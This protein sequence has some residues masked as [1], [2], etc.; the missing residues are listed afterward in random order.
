MCWMHFKLFSFQVMRRSFVLIA[1]AI[2][3]FGDSVT[4]SPSPQNRD[5][6]TEKSYGLSWSEFRQKNDG[7]YTEARWDAHVNRT[8][9]AVGSQ[10]KDLEE[11]WST[12]GKRHKRQSVC[13]DKEKK[14][15]RHTPTEKPPQE[16]STPKSRKQRSEKTPERMDARWHSERAKA[17]RERTLEQN[18]RDG[19]P[20]RQLRLRREVGGEE[21]ARERSRVSRRSGR[22]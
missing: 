18:V 13:A 8:D 7:A 11:Q 19:L 2:V 12:K 21:R 1:I 4:S 10:V 17:V 15:H 6:K 9:N 22:R 3:I 20:V 14:S 16:I 5:T